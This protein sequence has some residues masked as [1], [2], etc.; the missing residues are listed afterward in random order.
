MIFNEY[1][2]YIGYIFF[3]GLLI[4]MF[5]APFM[6][7]SYYRKNKRR[8]RQNPDPTEPARRKKV[9][10]ADVMDTKAGK[11][12]DKIADAFDRG[13]DIP[14]NYGPPTKHHLI[15]MMSV[16]LLDSEMGIERIYREKD[17]IMSPDYVITPQVADE[18]YDWLVA[19]YEKHNKIMAQAIKN[20]YEKAKASGFTLATEE[21]KSYNNSIN[22]L[23]VKNSG[24]K[25][26]GKDPWDNRREKD[27]W[28]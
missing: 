7:V 28:D 5:I 20:G 15:R 26:P 12:L 10:L 11:T 21:G 9:Y 13:P 4:A 8:Q 24:G 3:G 25:F 19:R 27:P 23:P 14:E 22:S 1:D 17:R 6:L 18:Y 2:Y 16:K